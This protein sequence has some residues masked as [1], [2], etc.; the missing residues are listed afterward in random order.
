MGKLHASESFA[1][2]SILSDESVTCSIVSA[3]HVELGII[4]PERIEG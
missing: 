4:K 2:I 1:E 3:T